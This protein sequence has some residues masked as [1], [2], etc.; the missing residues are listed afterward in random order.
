MNIAI[1]GGGLAGPV[2]A[3]LLQLHGVASTVYE[4]D[5]SIDARTQGGMLDLHEESGQRA[6]REIGLHDELR[7]LVHPQGEATRVVGK[8]GVV[9][10]DHEGGGGRPEVERGALRRLLLASLDPRTVAWG[11]K[12]AAVTS[13]GGGRHELAFTNGDRVAADL[14]VGADG[15]WSKVRPL[16]SSD[17]PAYCGVTFFELRLA[18]ADR[19]H[20]EVAALAG[21]GSLFA[22]AENKGL[23]THRLP[24]GAIDVY[25]GLRASADWAA[26][27]GV[28]WSDEG[29][30]RAAL[31]ALFEGWSDEVTRLLRESDHVMAPRLVHALPQGHSWSRVP[32]VTLVGDAAHLMS[33]FAGEGANLAMLDAAELGLALLAHPG[34]LEAALAH[35]EAAMFPRSAETAAQSSF[36]LDMCF[37]PDAPRALLAFFQSMGPPPAGD[38]A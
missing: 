1:V 27:A 37:A 18:D 14:V 16:L 32:G 21:P 25:V 5:A 7:Q 24:D 29:A 23:F 8:D 10:F 36:G 11:H 38:A 30:A 3:R 13:L 35:Y 28:D 34:D 19:R 17:K 31:L 20:P 2:L 26:S 4:L 22:L 6:L 9:L 33:P 15:A 12:L